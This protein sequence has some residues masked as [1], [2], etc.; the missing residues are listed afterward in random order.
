MLFIPTLHCT[1]ASLPVTGRRGTG[2]LG[3]LD[4]WVDHNPH[5]QQELRLE[6]LLLCNF[7]N[8]WTNRFF[9]CSFTVTDPSVASFR[10][11]VSIIVNQNPS[12]IFISIPSLLWQDLLTLPRV[13]RIMW[14]I[15]GV[16]FPSLPKPCHDL[17]AWYD[18]TF[19]CV[20]GGQCNDAL[21]ILMFLRL[22]AFI[23][24]PAPM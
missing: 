7:G 2:V 5:T 24:V 11:V 15:P 1:A 14:L 12:Y 21:Y 9:V 4:Q 22:R 10:L 13:Y 20:L 18:G 23:R 17:N 19:G 6:T 16:G 3:H 8:N